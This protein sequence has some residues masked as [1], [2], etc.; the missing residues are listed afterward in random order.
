MDSTEDA[1][2]TYV[3]PAKEKLPPY[4]DMILEAIKDADDKSKGTSVQ[5]IKKQ[6]ILKYPS[7]NAAAM[8]RNFKSAFTKL[9]DLEKIERVVSK[10]KDATASS[11][12]IGRFKINTDYL[13]GE[14]KKQKDKLK[15]QKLKEKAAAKGLVS[16]K[17][18]SVSQKLAK[19]KL[20]KARKSLSYKKDGTAVPGA[21]VKPAKKKAKV[22][23]NGAAAA[24]SKRKVP[25]KKTGASAASK[26]VSAKKK[27]AAAKK[28]S[29][30]PGVPK[31][32]SKA[33]KSTAGKKAKA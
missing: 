8:K 15:R 18:K 26:K 32:P 16:L 9:L 12:M 22:K 2:G 7:I 21:V 27:P 33:K 10:K 13:K 11:G 29:A 17:E 23:E 6:M 28:S 14:N 3:V 20:K 1:N 31:T 4:A 25:A 5:G 30:K 19:D 24:K